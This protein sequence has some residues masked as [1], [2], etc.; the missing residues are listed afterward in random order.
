MVG[1]LDT[2]PLVLLLR[3]LHEVQRD[4]RE[5]VLG[6]IPGLEEGGAGRSGEGRRVLRSANSQKAVAP[7]DAWE[8]SGQ[9]RR[10]RDEGGT[11]IFFVIVAEN[12]FVIFA[13]SNFL[14][15]LP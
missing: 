12:Y 15:I 5:Q 1:G 11:I 2:L 10:D 4:V 6:T 9:G 13:E 14:L 3:H 8:G 7:A